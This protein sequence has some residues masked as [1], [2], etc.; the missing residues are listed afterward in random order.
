MIRRCR[1]NS[2]HYDSRTGPFLQGVQV[3]FL[4]K[5]ARQKAAPFRERLYC[6]W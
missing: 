1:F 6:V 5:H 3:Y 4:S 2:L